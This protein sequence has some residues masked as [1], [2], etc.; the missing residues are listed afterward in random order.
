M[1]MRRRDS[2]LVEPAF[3]ATSAAVRKQRFGLAMVAL[4]AMLAASVP[5]GPASAQ[6]SALDA[7]P[8]NARNIG[9][10]RTRATS[11]PRS[12]GDQALV[13]GWPLYRTERGQTSFNDTMAVLQATEGR[14][15]APAAFKGCAALECALAL[16]AIGADGWIP[17][18]RLWVSASEYVLIVHS[19]R[20]RAGQSYRRRGL[21]EMRYFVYHEFH[22]GSRNTDTF[23]T[24]SSHSSSVYV[25]FYMSKQ[26]T[27][28]RGHRF[29]TVVQVA[30]YD[31]VSIHASN[32]GSAGPGVEVA[33]NVNDAAEPLQNLAGIVLGAIVKTAAPHLKVVNHRGSEGL[34][35]L[36]AY[37]Q[38]LSAIRANAGA[39][40]TLPFVPATSQQVV[41][42]SARLGDLIQRRG[43]SP[44]IPVAE[45]GIVPPRLAVATPSARPA[46]TPVAVT[47]APT[48]VTGATLSPLASYLR[49]NLATMK[50]LPEF[51]RLIPATVAAVGEE[52][53]D[54]GVVYLLDA[55]R[56]ILGRVEPYREGGRI[57]GGQFVYAPVD[58]AI[59]GETPFELDLAKPM[60][61]RQAALAP[62]KPDMPA[63]IEPIRPAVPPTAGTGN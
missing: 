52:S 3:L 2:S 5:T 15:P 14:P 1:R 40:V 11:L 46:P 32:Y 53:P 6:S 29:V 48:T 42:A 62:G 45:R 63:L 39:P 51:G 43:V 16:P 10:S 7:T 28:A 18:G 38:R 12:E 4:G 17:A 30:P 34:P 41:A 47:S 59:E 50:R 37:N 8:I 49:A 24:I 61:V 35:M 58:R 57:V 31:V 27:D 23:D 9:V 21:R 36:N 26:A 33:K 44:S 60:A 25:P 54:K 22:N 19:P 55:N 13:D 20:L 56:Q